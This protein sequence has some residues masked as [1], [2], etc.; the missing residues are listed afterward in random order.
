MRGQVK[1]QCTRALGIMLDLVVIGRL[2]VSA[3]VQR[4]MIRTRAA[5]HAQNACS[6]A[7]S[8]RVQ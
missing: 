3:D 1:Q 6:D 8:E 7:C 5:M 2:Q 4:R